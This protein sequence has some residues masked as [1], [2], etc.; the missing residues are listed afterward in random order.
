MRGRGDPVTSQR[1]S[2]CA[3]GAICADRGD[4]VAP[5]GAVTTKNTIISCT[6]E[7]TSLAQFVIIVTDMYLTRTLNLRY[8]N[9]R[10]N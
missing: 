7:R 10:I 2:T 9:T 1:N 4:M 3:P 8:Q 6:N 5:G